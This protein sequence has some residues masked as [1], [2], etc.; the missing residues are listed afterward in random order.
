MPCAP[1]EATPFDFRRG[2]KNFTSEALRIR[3][4]RNVLARAGRILPG[5][6]SRE[7]SQLRGSQNSMNSSF[8][9]R[10]AAIAPFTL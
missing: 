2:G 4:A 8:Q 10:C 9:V 6:P 7:V 3:M 1:Q 5:G